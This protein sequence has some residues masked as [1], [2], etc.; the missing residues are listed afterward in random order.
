MHAFA[1]TCWIKNLGGSCV[2]TWILHRESNPGAETRLQSPSVAGLP[3]C[4]R[5]GGP[6]R[7]LGRQL[8]SPPPCG[9]L[10]LGASRS[11]CGEQKYFRDQYY[12]LRSVSQT[13]LRP[14]FL[15]EVPVVH[16]GSRSPLH[17]RANPR[18]TERGNERCRENGSDCAKLVALQNPEGTDRSQRPYLGPPRSRCALLHLTT[19]PWWC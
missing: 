6:S 15:N 1:C 19:K 18:Q 8:H 9:H 5:V 4:R 13:Q 2:G 17:L 14:L 11:R 10:A 3:P 16:P 7:V 12:N